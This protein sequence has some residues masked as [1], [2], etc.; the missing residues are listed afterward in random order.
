MPKARSTYFDTDY[1]VVLGNGEKAKVVILK[2]SLPT[3]TDVKTWRAEAVATPFF[4]VQQLATPD[5]VNM[6]HGVVASGLCQIPMMTNTRAIKAWELL[7][8]QQ[9]VE[10]KAPET[11]R[12]KKK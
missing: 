3:S 2:P 4:F 10:P 7:A 6:E 5:D 8:V 9:Q 1:E 11:K 12:A